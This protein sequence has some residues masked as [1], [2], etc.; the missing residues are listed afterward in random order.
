MGQRNTLT[1]EQEMEFEQ[2]KQYLLD[3][4]HTTLEFPFGDD[5]YGF[6]VKGKM[7]ALIGFRGD[8]MNMNLKCDPDE[9]ESLREVFPDITAGYH[10]DKRHWITIYFRGGV[11][12]GEVCRLIDNS[13][14]LVVAKMTKKDQASILVNL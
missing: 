12:D 11:P 2:L 3:K 9:G 5:V 13:F 8:E 10:M 1:T 4:P 6:K 7:F 14:R